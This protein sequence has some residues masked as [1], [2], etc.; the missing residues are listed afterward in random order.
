MHKHHFDA[1]LAPSITNLV[2]GDDMFLL[3]NSKE[4]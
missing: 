4:S 3:A 2:W 1:D